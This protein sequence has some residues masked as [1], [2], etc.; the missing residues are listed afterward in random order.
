MKLHNILLSAVLTMV[1]AMPATAQREAVAKQVDMPHNYYWRE[2]YLPQL[3]AGPSWLAFYPDGKSLLYSMSGSL[4]RQAIDGTQATE[5]THAAG[6]Y[7]Y[8][9]DISLDG[10]H[11]VFSRYDGRSLE[12]W[13]LDLAT[14]KSQAL[15]HN[16]AF[17]AE[18]RYAPD[19][20]RLVWVSS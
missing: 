8:Q 10:R 20:K 5:I 13:Q 12:L 9:P 15:T 16:G 19:G 6:A 3:T 11:A 1:T 17:N 14:G 4:W 7:D 18:P 2:M